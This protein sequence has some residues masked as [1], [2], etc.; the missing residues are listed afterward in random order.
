MRDLPFIMRAIIN[1]ILYVIYLLFFSIAFSFIFP[2]ILQTLGK[3]IMNPTDPTF[4]KV[5]LFIA[6]LLLLISLIWR[7]YFYLCGRTNDNMIVLEEHITSKK[8]KF[9][10]NEKQEDIKIFI[11]REMK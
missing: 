5:Q 2:L 7:K 3:P 10:K 9:D 4:A 8:P 11:D 6:I 1:L